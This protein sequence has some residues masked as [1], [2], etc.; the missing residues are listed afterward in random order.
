M[1][2]SDPARS[3]TV[4]TNAAGRRWAGMNAAASYDGGRSA[5]IT[6]SGVGR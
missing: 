2:S 4:S 6:S 5:A 1:A 3:S